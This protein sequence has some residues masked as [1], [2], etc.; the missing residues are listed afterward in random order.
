[1]SSPS[2]KSDKTHSK[3]KLK[4]LHKLKEVTD[5]YAQKYYMLWYPY[6]IAKK[7]CS[8]TVHGCTDCEQ[9]IYPKLCNRDAKR[10]RKKMD[11]Y[12]WVFTLKTH[13]AYETN[14]YYKY[15][16]YDVLQGLSV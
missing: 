3:K 14:W 9:M 6:G 1:M 5:Y 2:L 12:P 10:V 16:H 13:Q 11:K 15:D 8:V 4:L 7:V